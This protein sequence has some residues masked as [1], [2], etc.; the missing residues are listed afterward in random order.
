M[1]AMRTTAKVGSVSTVTNLLGGVVPKAEFDLVDALVNLLLVAWSLPDGDENADVILEAAS[2]IT[3]YVA[4]KEGVD[5]DELMNVV[6]SRAENIAD[7]QDEGEIL[8]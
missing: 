6:Q 7:A 3:V 4:Q 2:E 8:H 1:T 5:T